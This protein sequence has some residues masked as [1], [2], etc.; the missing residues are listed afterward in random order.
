MTS[1]EDK[2]FSIQMASEASGVS[3]HTIRAWEKRYNAVTPERTATGRRV[4]SREDVN[5]LILL[6]Q[7]TNIGSAISQVANLPNKE[8][9][10]IF[11]RLMK[12]TDNRPTGPVLSERKALPELKTS[13]L[14][15]VKT[16]DVGEVSHLLSH[17][18]D[19]YSPGDF[20]LKILLP[21]FEEIEEGFK[22]G[23]FQ[24]AQFYA[25]KALVKFYGEMVIYSNRSLEKRPKSKFLLMGLSDGKKDLT[26]L[27]AA[28]ICYERGKD[29]FYLN[30][31]LPLEALIETASVVKASHIVL[32]LPQGVSAITTEKFLKDLNNDLLSD[33]KILLISM[34]P[35]KI[36]PLKRM[37][38]FKDLYEL[39]NHLANQD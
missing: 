37:E 17:A 14:A 11:L 16:Y 23:A 6:V 5:R 26:H 18:K 28:L 3:A 1:D 20:A 32:H 34:A 22:T 12:N 36:G 13:L 39:D 21:V 19:A 29:Y 38:L 7:L 27:L 9:S 24:T 4:Y 35:P 25:L 30:S 15:A 2:R 8:L 31:Q 33:V 10:E